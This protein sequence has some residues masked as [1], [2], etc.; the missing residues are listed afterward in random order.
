MIL[1]E[2]SFESSKTLKIYLS[3]CFSRPVVVG[4]IPVLGVVVLESD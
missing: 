4:P 2:D 1:E 3:A